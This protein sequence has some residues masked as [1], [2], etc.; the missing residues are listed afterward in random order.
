LCIA[1]PLAAGGGLACTYTPP[2]ATDA[3]NCSAVT[4]LDDNT[5]CLAVVKAVGGGV[6][7]TYNGTDT[8]VYRYQCD[9]GFIC[10][11]GSSRPEPTDEVTGTYCP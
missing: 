1:V 7:C 2:D 10:F 4:A 11:G 8:R 3:T 6:A 5:A 9:A